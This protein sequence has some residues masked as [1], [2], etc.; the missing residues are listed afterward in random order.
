[1]V[2]AFQQGS[3]RSEFWE[4]ASTVASGLRVPKPLGDF[5]I[6]KAVRESGGTAIA[7]SDAELLDAGIQ[8]ASEEGLFVAPEGAACVSALEKLLADGTLKR[9]EKIVIYNTGAGLKYLE[10][11]STRF[12]RQASSEQDKLGGL[13]TPR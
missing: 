13:I 7:V 9:D 6:L 11:Y 8:L 3:V 4:H 2:R 1:V 5:L 10:A 12:P